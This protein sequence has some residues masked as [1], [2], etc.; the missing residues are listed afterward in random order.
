[1]SEERGA[2]AGFPPSSEKNECEKNLS[3][4]RGG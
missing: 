3:H 4:V 1:M 2:R